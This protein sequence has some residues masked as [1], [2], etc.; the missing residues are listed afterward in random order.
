MLSRPCLSLSL[1]LILSLGPLS[2][3][4]APGS[5]PALPPL[6]G[7][8]A[9]HGSALLIRQEINPSRP[10]SVVG[11]R[12]A[13][14]GQED[15]VCSAWI[16]PWKILSDLR[17]VAHLQNYDVPIEVNPQ[18]AEIEVTAD[19]TILTYSHANFTIR[20]I[21]FAPKDAPQ[22]AGAIILYQI[23]AI[24]PMT[25][26][27]SFRPAFQRMWPAP[28]DPQ[29]SPEWVPTPESGA[30]ASGFYILHEDL[31]GH[32]TAIAMPTAGPGILAPYQERPRYWPLQF[33][34]HFD[35]A[36]DHNRLYPLLMVVGDNPKSSTRDALA[37]SLAALD[38]SIPALYKQ[39]TAYYRNLLANNASIDT[40]DQKLNEA[41]S[42]AI[43]AI[44]QLKVAT[45]AGTGEALTA[46]FVDSGDSDRPGFGWF[47]GRD[48]LW[49]LYAVD[50]YGDTQTAQ[51]ELE[52][53]IRHQR[54]DGKI[55]HEYSQTANLVDWS[56]LPYE[57]AAADSTPL[58]LMAAADYLR[59]SGDARFIRTHWDALNQAWKFETS[60]ISVDGIYNNSQGSGWVESW[61]PSMP[62]QEIYLAAL[63]QQAS[64]AFADLAR[65]SGHADLAEEASGRASRLAAIIEKE[66]FLPNSGFYAFSRN[67][68]GT[69]DPTATIFPAVAWWDGTFRLDA[70]ERMFERW[71]SS[72]FSTDW[73]TRILSDQTSFYD[74]ISYHQGSVWPLF[75]GWSSVA[76]YRAGQPLSAWNHLRQNADLTWTEDPGHVTELLSG[77]FFHVLGR[78][79]AHQLWS[80]AMVISPVMRGLFG[81]E[82]NEAASTLT[83]T[84]HLP[85]EWL[86]ASL[87]RV[88]FG[89][90]R[91]EI[92]M[93]RHGDA[94]AVRVQGGSPGLR[95]ESRIPGAGVRNGE[96][97]IPLPAVE[98][99][100][101]ELLPPFG[102]ETTNL[103][104][105][106][107]SYEPRALILRLASPAGSQATIDVRT[108]IP[109]KHLS[110]TGASLGDGT[111]ELRRMQ[112]S[113]PPGAG[114]VDKTVSLRW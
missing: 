51:Q 5:L 96:L 3:Q 69:T 20:Q 104:V 82:W 14:L 105:L 55:M 12:G 81:M 40:P 107:E 42:W 35:P 43:A 22:G 110:A 49:A 100:T 44:D 4:T 84:P 17:I 111:S 41:F 74:P 67:P 72:E 80:S 39:N 97:L 66:Y 77:R 64:T 7:F 95:L 46:G 91:L 61:I 10:F 28:S 13:L 108:N 45:P 58:F 57:Y 85:A 48:A 52:F 102:S 36:H 62:H 24:R 16:F 29:P 30:N 87:H 106:W 109:L 18:A 23:Q 65:A 6:P 21:M 53:L 32:A 76:E 103:K 94:L 78:S 90:S 63:D 54:Q 86:G 56:A 2:A 79:T 93:V 34:L 37:Q 114:Y 19:A 75:T 98:V 11:P 9:A 71:A 33:E 89:K 25:L 31:P 113:F 15:G 112:I 60:H 8:P 27:F 73:G 68:D 59:I 101:E 50:S 38:V 70:T 83:I 47:F 92:T 26:T 88:P 1:A 99:G